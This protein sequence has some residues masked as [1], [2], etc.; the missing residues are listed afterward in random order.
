MSILARHFFACHS[1]EGR[2]PVTLQ[3]PENA[4]AL[5]PGFRRDDESTKVYA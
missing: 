3:A 5:G 1:G 2:N 4:K